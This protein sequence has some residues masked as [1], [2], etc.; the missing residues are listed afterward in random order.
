MYLNEKEKELII[1][2]KLTDDKVARHT[3][4]LEEGKLVKSYNHGCNREK[5]LQKYR[6]T[7][8]DL[9]ESEE[10]VILFIDKIVEKYKCTFEIS[11]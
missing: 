6:T 4:F 1:L 2:H 9:F 10:K 8:I 3:I 5:T 7:M 11:L